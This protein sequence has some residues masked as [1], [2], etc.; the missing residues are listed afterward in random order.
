MSS[1]IKISKHKTFEHFVFKTL[2]NTVEFIS[3]CNKTQTF[4]VC[5]SDF[6]NCKNC[7]M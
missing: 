5:Y 4:R 3:D 7:Y 6:M 1:S 2:K